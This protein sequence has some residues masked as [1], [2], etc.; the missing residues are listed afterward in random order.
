MSEVF[1]NLA[2]ST[3]AS[4]ITAGALSLTVQSGDGND[5]FPVIAGLDNFRCFIFKKA[6]GDIEIINVTARTADVFTITRAQEEIGNIAATAFAFDAGDIIEHRPSSAFYTSLSSGASSTNIQQGVFLYGVDTGAADVYTVAMTP[7]ATTL[8]D[9]QEVRVKIGAGNTN[10]GIAATL[11]LDAVA[12]KSI[13]MEDGGNPVAGSILTGFV[14]TFIYNGIAFI[15]NN[16]ISIVHKDKVQVLTNKELTSPTITSPTIASPVINTSVS[17]TAGVSRMFE[18][19]AQATTS[20]SSIDYTSIPSWVKKITISLDGVSSNGTNN[21]AVSIGDS[22][23]LELSGYVSRIFRISATGASIQNSTFNW[24]IYDMNA[25][26][27]LGYGTIILSLLDSS[28]NT[29]VQSGNITVIGAASSACLSAGSKS[30]TGV[31]DRLQILTPDTFDAGKVN[32]LYE[33]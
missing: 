28:T 30:L 29:W 11:Q 27:D 14:H 10:T 15:L 26:S 5:L 20:G 7:T 2:R 9:G 19:V 4:G 16:S 6:T 17:G 21:I 13:L 22:D 23:G 18:G 25:A 32:I 24:Q 31:L 33:G 12:A 1:N 3:L 8:A